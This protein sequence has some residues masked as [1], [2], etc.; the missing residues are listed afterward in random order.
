VIVANH[1]R[2]F[3]LICVLLGSAI[4]TVSNENSK[5]VASTA[6]LSDTIP[7][8]FLAPLTG[9]LGSYGPEMQKGAELA[10]WVINTKWGGIPR[11]GLPNAT[12]DLLVRDTATSPATA[13][14]AAATL[15]QNYGVHV[16]VGAAGSRQT[17]AVAAVTSP[18][19]VV[20]LSYAS[21]SPDITSQGGDYTFRV[22]PSDALQGWALADLALGK[23]YRNAAAMHLD[24][25]YGHWMMEAFREKFEAAGGIVVQEIP[26]MKTAASFAAEIAAIKTLENEESIDVIVDISYANDGAKIFTEAAAQNITT[27]W[28]CAEGVAVPYIFSTARVGAAMRGMWG[29]KFY[30]NTSTAE[31]Q[32]FLSYFNE[33]YPAE[34][35]GSFADYA[36]DAVML[37]VDAIIAAAAY[38]GNKIKETLYK[39]SQGW[40]GATGDK[41]FDA[42]GDVG[43]D[44]LFWEV[45][46][47]IPG[48]FEFT[49]RK[50]CI[51][52]VPV[53]ITNSDATISGT[54]KT[55]SHSYEWEDTITKAPGFTI[56]V[57]LFFGLV[58][59][60]ARSLRA[61]NKDPKH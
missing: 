43:Q 45:T 59:L 8:G 15:M 28:V 36:Y 21:T 24:N 1:H 23:G 10:E 35:P 57:L 18:A 49:T 54:S 13:A 55:E 4:W 2:H 56:S 39:V 6:S 11:S 7:I 5:P 19:Q 61:I 27:P 41:N 38:D 37:V 26:Y 58:V 9:T 47:P 50:C 51:R 14:A 46:E 3:F 17:L 60:F 40:K 48:T 22:T 53:N 42:N 44:L 33:K 12:I 25:D 52:P 16:I 32:Q 29:T 31:Y 34:T 20:L 30:T